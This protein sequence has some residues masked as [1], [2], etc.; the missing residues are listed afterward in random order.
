MRATIATI[1]SMANENTPY[2]YN[3]LS[4]LNDLNVINV[5]ITYTDL[6]L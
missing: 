2:K 5:L 1:I 6:I 3:W 4:D